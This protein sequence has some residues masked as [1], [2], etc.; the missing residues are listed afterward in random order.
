MPDAN[1]S[2]SRSAALTILCSALLLFQIQPIASKAILAWF[3]GASSVWTTSMLF[4]Q[5]I[6]VGGY[7]YAHLLGRWDLKRQIK[8]HLFVV[9]SACLCLPLSFT[10]PEVST[11]A[12]QPASTIMILLLGAVGLPYFVLSTTGPLVQNWYALT[13]GSNTPYRLYSLS[14]AGSLTA[15]LTYPFLIEVYL[16]VPTQSGVWSIG[17]LL[18]TAS[19][20]LL[21]WRCHKQGQIRDQ[22]QTSPRGAIEAPPTYTR[23]AK[24]TGLAA[25]ASTILLA[26]T[27]QLTQDIAVTPFLW[28]LPLSLYLLSFIIAFDNPRWYFRLSFTG[29]T[30]LGILFLSLFY[31]RETADEYLGFNLFQSIAENLLLYTVMLVTVFFM[32]CM[33][34]HGELFR[35]RPDKQHLTLYY[36]CIAMGGAAGGFFV[37]VFCPFI[38]SSYHEYHLGLIV[39]FA[40]AGLILVRQILDKHGLIQL[41]VVIPCGLAFGIVVLSQWKM[42]QSD[43]VIK[44]RNFYGTLHVAPDPDKE[45]IL[46]LRHGRVAHGAQILDDSAALKPTTYYGAESGIGQVFKTLGNQADLDVTT[47]GLGVGTLCAYARRGDTFRFFEINPDVVALANSHFRFLSKASIN[48]EVIV[49]DGRMGIQTLPQHS[50]DL[51]ILDAFSSDAIPVHLLTVEAF[52]LYL[53]RLREDGIICVHISNQHLDLVPVLAALANHNNLFLRTFNSIATVDTYDAQWAILTT[54]ETF[55]T[56]LQSNTK[57]ITPS[58]QTHLVPWTDQFSNLLQIIK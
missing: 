5:T 18:F 31:I 11:A 6:L 19:I 21:G 49:A 54:N 27:D 24:W 43:A 34:C 36:L 8:V 2:I 46:V 12:K 1:K 20:G 30:S 48:A 56:K 17:F 3:G 44:T 28:I 32:I 4:F 39:T 15:L 41:T 47:V 10:S 35:L 23:M 57:L 25:L 42:T 33:T 9:L 50:T 16:D 29:M 45:N 55:L 7:C 53:S 40:L 52:D 51:I 38:F 37:T 26:V 13:Q 14:N 58:N 22:N